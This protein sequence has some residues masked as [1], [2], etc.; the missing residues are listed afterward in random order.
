[1]CQAAIVVDKRRLI[2]LILPWTKKLVDAD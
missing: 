1:M 2:S